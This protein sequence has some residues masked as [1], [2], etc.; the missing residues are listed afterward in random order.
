M[1][2]FVEKDKFVDKTQYFTQ[3][4]ILKTFTDLCKKVN[5]FDPETR[6]FDLNKSEIL[7]KIFGCNQVFSE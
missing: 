2:R 6:V 1:L 4:Q 7:Q 3:E 5:V